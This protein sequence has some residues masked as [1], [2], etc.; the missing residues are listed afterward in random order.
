MALKFDEQMQCMSELSS[1]VTTVRAYAGSE[2][3]KAIA[4]MLDALID[5]CKLDLIHVS[6]EDLPR[7][8]AAI[9]QAGAIRAVVMDETIAIPKI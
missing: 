3:S 7:L 2:A 1:R 5:S 6:Q 4:S 9:L 8:Q